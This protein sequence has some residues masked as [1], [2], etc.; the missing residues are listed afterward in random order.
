MRQIRTLDSFIYYCCQKMK[1][2]KLSLSWNIKNKHQLCMTTE[3]SSNP[4]TSLRQREAADTSGRNHRCS[5]H[6][7]VWWE[8]ALSSESQR[9]LEKCLNRD[10]LPILHSLKFFLTSRVRL[11]DGVARSIERLVCTAPV[12]SCALYASISMESLFSWL[13]FYSVFNKVIDI[14]M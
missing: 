1:L 4:S 8:I 12:F 11:S 5:M 14:L 2:G 9:A 13:T 3:S 6:V 7:S 10:K